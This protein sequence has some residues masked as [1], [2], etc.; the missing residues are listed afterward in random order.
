MS[1]RILR[2]N[3]LLQRELG[4]LFLEEMDFPRDILVTI[5]RVETASDLLESNVFISVLPDKEAPK[6]IGTLKKRIY[7][8]QQKI[9]K[10]LKMSPLPR[11]K[12]LPEKK[13]SQAAKIE[14]VLEGL[15]RGKLSSSPS[16]HK[17]GLGN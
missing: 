10:R 8:L 13:T 9:N 5:T 2:I 12:F 14:E 11:L 7:S 15:K 6:V 1:R 16:S 17:V 3:A 4:Q